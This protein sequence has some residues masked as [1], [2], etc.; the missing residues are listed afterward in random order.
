MFTPT[1]AGKAGSISQGGDGEHGRLVP[2]VVQRTI[3]T[4]AASRAQML[5]AVRR[6]WPSGSRRRLPGRGDESRAEART[7]P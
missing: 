4:H 5:L 2:R 7:V 1:A 6:L 3:E